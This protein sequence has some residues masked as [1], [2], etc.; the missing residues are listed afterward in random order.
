MTRCISKWTLLAMLWPMAG[1]GVRQ[2]TEDTIRYSEAE[3]LVSLR[4][5]EHGGDFGLFYADHVKAEVPVRV[6][7]G[8]KV[9]FIRVEDGGMKAV[10]GPFKM[11][12]SAA[13]REAYWKRLPHLED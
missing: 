11:D 12:M 9:G 7:G 2:P 1:C 5:V 13:V 8:D 6:N 10:A 4:S 3:N